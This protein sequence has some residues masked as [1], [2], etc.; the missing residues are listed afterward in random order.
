MFKFS[1]EKLSGLR[2]TSNMISNGD[3][4]IYWPVQKALPTYFTRISFYDQ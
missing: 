4:D 3:L 1:Y 2:W